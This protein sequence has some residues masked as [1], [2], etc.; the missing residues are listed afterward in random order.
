MKAT[1]K[2]L[3]PAV[4]LVSASATF[5]QGTV[6]PGNIIF[7]P[8]AAAPERILRRSRIPAMRVVCSR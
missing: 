8:P 2:Y 7:S 6:V 3:L 1:K 5:A 4:I